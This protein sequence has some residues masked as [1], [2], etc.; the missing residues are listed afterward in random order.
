[1]QPSSIIIILSNH[2]AHRACLKGIQIDQQYLVT[3]A[4][5]LDRGNQQDGF[6]L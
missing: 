4:S 6:I 2:F 5:Q 1:M 3:R